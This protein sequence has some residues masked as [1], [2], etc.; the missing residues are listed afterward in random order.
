MCVMWCGAV[1]RVC[2]YGIRER[3]K[4]FVCEKKNICLSVFRLFFFFFLVAYNICFRARGTDGKVSCVFSLFLSSSLSCFPSVCC[5]SHYL[6][7]AAKPL[8]M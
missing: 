7:N 8:A 6:Q 3:E 2:V 5:L 1:L 4:V